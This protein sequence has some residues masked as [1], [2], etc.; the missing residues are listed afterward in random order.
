MCVNFTVFKCSFHWA[1]ADL[2]ASGSAS[3][4]S[5]GTSSVVSEVASEIP[6]Q[7]QLHTIHSLCQRKREKEGGRDGRGGCH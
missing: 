3:Y 1:M 5:G 7:V 4:F 6:F 2:A